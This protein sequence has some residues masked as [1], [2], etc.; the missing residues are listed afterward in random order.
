M[1]HTPQVTD[2][3]ELFSQ[4]TPVE[5]VRARLDELTLRLTT[6]E[7]AQEIRDIAI[8]CAA[9]TNA[10]DDLERIEGRILLHKSSVERWHKEIGRMLDEC[11]KAGWADYDSGTQARVYFGTKEGVMYDLDHYVK[12]E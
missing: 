11:E 8:A 4:M 12:G 1:N 3:Q 6:E 7:S 9:L 10:V 2:R 5:R